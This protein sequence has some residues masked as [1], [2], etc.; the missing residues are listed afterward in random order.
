MTQIRFGYDYPTKSR[1]K[2]SKNGTKSLDHNRLNPL[3]L[4]NKTN[5]FLPY[6]CHMISEKLP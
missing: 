2:N 4:A 1:F 5:Q 6:I 3:I